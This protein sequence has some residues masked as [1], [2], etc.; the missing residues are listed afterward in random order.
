MA[1]LV[2]PKSIFD[3]DPR[4]RWAALSTEL[5][6]V[7]F[8]EMRPGVQSHTSP[9]VDRA[10]MKL[11]PIVMTGISERLTPGGEVGPVD[12]VIINFE[13]DSVLLKKIS[14]GYLALS[15]E[16]ADATLALEAISNKIKAL[17]F[18]RVYSQK[19]RSYT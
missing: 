6:E 11:G 12:N 14:H 17:G 7:V 8:S 5:G 18:E 9:E 19:P 15:V 2:S 1:A 4:V 16:R 10:F 3:L 13:K